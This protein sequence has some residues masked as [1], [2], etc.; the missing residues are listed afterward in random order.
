MK[1]LNKKNLENVQGGLKTIRGFTTLDKSTLD[2]T[3]TY[4]DLNN[5]KLYAY[6]DGR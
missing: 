6:V 4:I 3:E 5:G 2:K 1:N